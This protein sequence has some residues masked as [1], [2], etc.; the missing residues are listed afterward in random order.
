MKLFAHCRQIA[1]KPTLLLVLAALCV[2]NVTVAEESSERELQIEA[3]YLFHF[4]QFTEWPTPPTLIHYCVYDDPNF[5]D[6]LQKTYNN[7][8]IGGVQLDVKN[9]NAQTPLDECQII[10]FP[11]T[12]QTDFLEKLQKHA[13]LTVGQQKDF[14]KSGGI[15]YLFEENQKLRFYINNAVATDAGLKIS[16][17]LL[18][19]SK[20]P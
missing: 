17:Q 13:I 10:Y 9:I 19:L 1:I 7:K 18:K 15:I 11:K 4:T 3:A 5:T 20:E 8:T 16:S 12:V 14:S 6:L 2:W